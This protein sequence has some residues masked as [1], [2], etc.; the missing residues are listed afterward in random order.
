MKIIVASRYVPRRQGESD[1]IFYICDN[2]RTAQRG[3]GRN[4]FSTPSY[5][6]I[7][8][9]E[10][11]SYGAALV[12]GYDSIEEFF[13]NGYE[14]SDYLQ[15]LDDQDLGAGWPIVYAIRK[16][17]GSYIFKHYDFNEFERMRNSV[18]STSQMSRSH[19]IVASSDSTIENIE[20]ELCHQ[21]WTR[22]DEMIEEIEELGYEVTYS[23]NEYISIVDPNVD[24]DQEYI[25]YLGNTGSTIWVEDICASSL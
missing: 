10:A 9:E 15:M 3:M 1:Y 11:L 20:S 21:F 14:G 13:A 18:Y 22:L 16:A 23:N 17:H 12:E 7:S 2:L 4:S 25:L 19:R 24:K 6:F 5:E 8:D